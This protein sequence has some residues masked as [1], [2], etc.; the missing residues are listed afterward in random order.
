MELIYQL[1]AQCI[2]LQ[3]PPRQAEGKGVAEQTIVCGVA[4]SSLKEGLCGAMRRTRFCKKKLSRLGGTKKSRLI[5]GDLHCKSFYQTVVSSVRES[6]LQQE[7]PTEELPH[8]RLQPSRSR[9]QRPGSLMLR[10]SQ[11]PSHDP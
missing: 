11:Q 7:P 9:P 8:P 4:N 6:P 1:F 3:G 10:C 2:S 5:R